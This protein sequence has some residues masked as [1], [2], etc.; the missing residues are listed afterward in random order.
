MR[1]V[2]FIVTL[3]FAAV[4]YAADTPIDRWMKAVGGR[5]KVAAIKSIHREGTLQW[6]GME[7]SIK[8][9]HTAE[10]KYRKEEQI[11]PLSS[12]ETFDGATGVVQQGS[13]PA[14]K[15]GSGELPR[16]ISSAYANSNAM[17]FVFFPERR[18]GSVSMEG[19]D[20]IVMHPEGGIEWRVVLDPQ[21]S[22]PKTMT[23][24]EGDRTINVTFVSYETV[25]GL[26]LE[27]EIHRT[28]GDPRFSSDIRFSK[29][30]INPPIEAAL[31]TQPVEAAPKSASVAKE[32]EGTWSGTIDAQ[33]VQKQVGLKIVNHPDGTATG[34]I[35]SDGAEIPIST[36]LQKGS[37]VTLDL[38]SVG[39]SYAGTLNAAATELAGTW[40]QGQFVGPLNFHRVAK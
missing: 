18:R 39:G 27:K 22:L 19:D 31:F 6:G 28:A 37:S 3:L 32:L 33:G 30:V 7:G 20:T 40:T 12:V 10:G 26:T 34:V 5:D 9:W 29:T 36:M 17:F 8:V 4:A 15:M 38:K 13:G 11:G 23:H 2:V 16:A 35:S 25:D 21:T 24:Q 14:R 1:K